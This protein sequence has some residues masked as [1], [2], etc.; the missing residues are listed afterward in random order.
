MEDRIKTAKRML[1]FWERRLKELTSAFSVVNGVNVN[2]KRKEAGKENLP[3]TPP[4]REKGE[5]KKTTT[6]TTARARADSQDSMREA[7]IAEV[8]AYRA[9]TGSDIDP[10]VFVDYYLSN[11][12]G[13]PK[14]WQ[15]R[16][17]NWTRNGNPD[18]RLKPDRPEKPKKVPT[19]G[20]LIEARVAELN[21][22]GAR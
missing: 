17:R 1:R 13:W 18:G 19:L 3:P 4:I 8:E 16:F 7:R 11:H 5:E 22:G 21:L 10:E 2:A 6:T 15:A 20:E 12:R 14:N 9:E